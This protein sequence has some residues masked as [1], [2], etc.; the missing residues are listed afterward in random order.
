MPKE[1]QIDL[2]VAYHFPRGKRREYGNAYVGVMVD[3]ENEGFVMPEGVSRGMIEVLRKF[4]ADKTELKSEM[5]H[6]ENVVRLEPEEVPDYG[7]NED[8]D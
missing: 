3:A 7:D 8:N 4:L 6:I 2:F 1:M 5:I